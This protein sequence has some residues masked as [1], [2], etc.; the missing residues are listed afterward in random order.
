MI[1]IVFFLIPLHQLGIDF[2]RY[3]YGNDIVVP[4]TVIRSTKRLRY[5]SVIVCNKTV[6]IRLALR[7]VKIA[8]A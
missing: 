3:L 7:I 2:W 4:I 5:G 1:V 8:A 6:R